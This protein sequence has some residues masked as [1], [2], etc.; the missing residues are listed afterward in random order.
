MVGGKVKPLTTVE[1]F[2]E[3][4]ASMR[5]AGFGCYIYLLLYFQV[6]GL[7]DFV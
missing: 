3:R 7:A 5:E 6:L 4:I 2:L 1:I